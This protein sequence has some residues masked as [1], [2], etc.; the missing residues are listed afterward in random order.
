MV[1]QNALG[2]FNKIIP[3]NPIVKCHCFI[4]NGERKIMKNC[5]ECNPDAQ[6][7]KKKKGYQEPFLI[8]DC[9]RYLSIWKGY[10]LMKALPIDIHFHFTRRKCVFEY[11]DF[12]LWF[13]PISSCRNL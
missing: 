8:N 12:I 2:K 7:R 6:E 4:T 11:S 10:I 3:F 1:D 5:S 13:N 9:T